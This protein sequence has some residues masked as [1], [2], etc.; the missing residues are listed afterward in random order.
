MYHAYIHMYTQALYDRGDFQV[1]FYATK[2]IDEQMTTF[3]YKR[4]PSLHQINHTI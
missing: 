3:P 4:F 1:I 2:E